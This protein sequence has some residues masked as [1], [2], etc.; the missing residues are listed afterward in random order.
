M[1][2]RRLL[3]RRLTPSGPCQPSFFTHPIL[4]DQY[5]T[6]AV[7]LEGLVGCVTRGVRD[8]SV[9][10]HVNGPDSTQES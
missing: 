5:I 10:S 3:A 4:L 7:N 6:C 9:M 1:T 2:Y 8:V